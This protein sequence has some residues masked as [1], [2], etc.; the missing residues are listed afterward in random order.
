MNNTSGDHLKKRLLAT[1]KKMRQSQRLYGTTVLGARGQVVIPAE[2][3]KEFGLNAG[4]QLVILGNSVGKV[5]TI[6]ESNNLSKFV[7]MITKHLEGSG[8]EKDIRKDFEKISKKIK[9]SVK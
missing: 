4:D 2:A 7:G 8:L 9:H 6:I 5:L 3:R 1:H